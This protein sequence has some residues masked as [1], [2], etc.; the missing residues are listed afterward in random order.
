MIVTDH[1]PLVKIFGDCTLDE[2]SNSHLFQLKQRTLPWRFD[3]VHQPGKTN[4]AADATSRHP[5]PSS[6]EICYSLGIPSESDL[7]ESALM[8]SIREDSQALSAIPWALLAQE[9]TR[10]TS[11]GRALCLLE[12][13]GSIDSRDPALACLSPICE[14]IYAQDG[15]LMYNDCVV[16]PSSLRPRILQHLHEVEKSAIVKRNKYLITVLGHFW[17][18]W[19]SEYLTQL[20]EHHR[21]NKR[22]GPVINVGDVVTVKEDN[23]K[24]LNWQ[25]AL[26]DRKGQKVLSGNRQNNGQGW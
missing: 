3:I 9:T 16:V 19:S 17:K 18:R 20:R 6:S 11:L 25:M 21:S 12:R 7:A 14:S 8:A 5:S 24:Q 26:V 15:V 22:D 4:H 13:N 10:D 1:K 2:I 23:V